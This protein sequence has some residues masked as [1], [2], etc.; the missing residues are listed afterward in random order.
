[1]MGMYLS[2]RSLPYPPW[3]CSKPAIDW[4]ESHDTSLHKVVGRKVRN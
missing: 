3:A 4:L 1:M 2:E